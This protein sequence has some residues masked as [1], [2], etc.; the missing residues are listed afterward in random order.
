MITQK[1]RDAA[2]AELIEKRYAVWPYKIVLCSQA[3]FDTIWNAAPIRTH[4]SPLDN[5]TGR[6]AM[7]FEASGSEFWVFPC[8]SLASPLEALE[9]ARSLERDELDER[10]A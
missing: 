8:M 5:S 1:E 10:Y 9:A 7:R 3:E 4:V 6:I 2:V